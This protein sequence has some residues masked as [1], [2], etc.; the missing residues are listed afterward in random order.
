MESTNIEKVRRA[1]E[2]N[3]AVKE[4]GGGVKVVFWEPGEEN[5]L[6]MTSAILNTASSLSRMR[7]KNLTIE[8]VMQKSLITLI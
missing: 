7:T 3:K 2:T 1:K 4:A 6:R 8:L 5:I